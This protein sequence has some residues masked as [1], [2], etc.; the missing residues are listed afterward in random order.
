MIGRRGAT[1]L[2]ADL[3]EQV[4]PLAADIGRGQADVAG[5]VRYGRI[6]RRA[7]RFLAAS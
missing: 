1:A 7:A 4:L 5:V 6:N 2:M 3:V